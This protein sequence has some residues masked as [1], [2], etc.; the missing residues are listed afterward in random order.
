M[1]LINSVKHEH[2]C[3]IVLFIYHSPLDYPELSFKDA[4][5]EHIPSIHEAVI[6]IIRH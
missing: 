3:Q 6:A 5:V 2:E 4:N 1:W